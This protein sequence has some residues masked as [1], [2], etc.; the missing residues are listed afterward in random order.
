MGFRKIKSATVRIG[1]KTLPADVRQEG[2]EIKIVL[3]EPVTLSTGEK[4]SILV[5]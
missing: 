2:A 3:K 4:L 1:A 5:V